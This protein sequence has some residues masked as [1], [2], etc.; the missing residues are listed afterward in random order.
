MGVEVVDVV[1]EE[2]V[3]EEVTEIVMAVAPTAEGEGVEEAVVV[4]TM[5]TGTMTTMDMAVIAEVEAPMAVAEGEEVLTVAAE[6]VVVEAR[7]VVAEIVAVE[8]RTA[9]VGIVAV[10]VRIE[11]AWIVAVEVGIMIVVVEED[12]VVEVDADEAVTNRTGL[13]L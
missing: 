10:E 7:T 9:V 4:R 5:T 6:I 2:E 13:F 1:E 3:V 12:V 11:E 8:A